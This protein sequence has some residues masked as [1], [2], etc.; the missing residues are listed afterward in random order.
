[1]PGCGAPLTYATEN[2][3]FLQFDKPLCERCYEEVEKQFGN[4]FN[5]HNLRDMIVH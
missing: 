3:V 1:M 5:I 4:D 2:I